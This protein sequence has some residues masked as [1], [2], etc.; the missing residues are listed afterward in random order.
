MLR[1]VLTITELCH[2]FWRDWRGRQDPHPDWNF[3]GGEA[4]FPDSVVNHTSYL[5][6]S[7]PSVRQESSDGQAGLWLPEQPILR[8]GWYSYGLIFIANLGLAV[9]FQGA[10]REGLQLALPLGSTKFKTNDSESWSGP[11]HVYKFIT[12]LCYSRYLLHMM[13]IVSHTD[14]QQ[15]KT[16]HPQSRLPRSGFRPPLVKIVCIFCFIKG[17]AQHLLPGTSSLQSVLNTFSC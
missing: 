17:L 13:C 15:N 14:K 6:L 9:L 12:S 5:G 4:Q 8:T 3:L 10:T 11:F 1:V 16:S 7:F 2:P